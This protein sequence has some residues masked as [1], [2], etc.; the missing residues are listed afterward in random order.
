MKQSIIGLDAR[1]TVEQVFTNAFVVWQARFDGKYLA[2]E[3][4]KYAA[5][6]VCR[7]DYRTRRLQ[8]ISN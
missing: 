1:Y 3:L 4:T 6:R 2:S 8:E 5:E 7:L